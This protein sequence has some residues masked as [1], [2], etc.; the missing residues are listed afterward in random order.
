MVANKRRAT[1]CPVI[2]T[3]ISIR[4]KK[5]AAEA[6]LVAAFVRHA[7]ETVAQPRLSY[8]KSLNLVANLRIKPQAARPIPV[9]VIT[10]AAAA[11]ASAPSART[12]A[13]ISQQRQSPSHEPAKRPAAAAFV[14]CVN[15]PDALLRV[16][17]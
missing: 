11:I 13:A 8:C 5:P 10:G 14:A 3:A 7:I 17:R 4:S 6:L 15:G 16:T 2:S 12:L 1:L 9:P